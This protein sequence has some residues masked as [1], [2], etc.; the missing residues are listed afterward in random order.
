MLFPRGCGCE[1][2]KTQVRRVL[3][4]ELILWSSSLAYP[5]VIEHTIRLLHGGYGARV[6]GEIDGTHPL[7]SQLPILQ[8]LRA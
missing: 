5:D 6:S 3:E 8:T 7:V 1:N 2:Y 4:P